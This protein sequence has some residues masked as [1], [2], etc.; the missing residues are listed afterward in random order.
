MKKTFVATTIDAA[1]LSATVLAQGPAPG[2]AEAVR[3]KQRLANMEAVL[4]RA[5]SSGAEDVLR[6]MQ[7][8]MSDRPFL[9]GLPQVRGFRLEGHGVFFYVQVPGLQLPIMWSM[10]HLIQAPDRNTAV[11]VQQ[12][13]TLAARVGGAE[14]DELLRIA[15]Q[16]E[17]QL[18][19]APT[20]PAGI[21]RPVSAAAVVAGVP[22]P[23]PQAPA[24]AIDP[25]LLENPHA[26]Y[27]REVKEAL[28]EAMLEYSQA[29]AIGDNEFLTVAARDAEPSNPLMVGDPIDFTTWIVRVRGSDLAALRAKTITMEE[30]RARVEI[31]EE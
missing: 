31:R 12:L 19:A 3:V 30:A 21:G 4:Q 9:Q 27:T 17:G 26:A 28:I 18:A 22:P 25:E 24:P 20:R 14:G 29:L 11:T 15:R 10:R 2:Q 6:Q 13:T 5:V 23:P 1:A 7:S 16:L 8:I